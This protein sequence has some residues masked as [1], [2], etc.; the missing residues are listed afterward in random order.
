MF[1]DPY[2]FELWTSQAKSFKIASYGIL[3]GVAL[4]IYQN[5]D[6][7]DK[8]GNLAEK[9]LVE[10]ISVKNIELGIGTDLTSIGD[11]V[12]KLY[13]T[14]S[15]YYA[16]S[17]PEANDRTMGIVWYN[18]DDDNQYLGFSDGV[19]DLSYDEEVYIAEAA[20][21]NKIAS[22]LGSSEYS[23]D[24]DSLL[25]AANLG[26]ATPLAQEIEKLV[27][28]TLWTEIQ[29]L[30]KKI[31]GKGDEL[32]GYLETAVTNLESCIS[33]IEKDYEQVLIYWKK[34]SE[35]SDPGIVTLSGKTWTN[36]KT[37]YDELK[38]NIEN[39]LTGLDKSYSDVID[40]YTN[41][42]N[43]VF[44]Q[45]EAKYNTLPI[46][47]YDV[48]NSYQSKTNFKTYQRKDFSAYANKYCIYWFRADEA[49]T[50]S[51]CGEGWSRIRVDPSSEDPQLF[52]KGEAVDGWYRN[53]ARTDVMPTFSMRHDRPQ[54]KLK[55]ILFYNHEKFESN[56][57]VF[58]NSEEIPDF[59]TLDKTDTGVISHGENSR[60]QYFVYNIAGALNDY[61]DRTRDRQLI[62]HYDGLLAKD[63]ALDY[64][65]IYWYIPNKD[66]ASMLLVS[67]KNELTKVNSDIAGYDAYYKKLGAGDEN[68]DTTRSFWYKIK[69]TYN[70]GFSFNTIICKMYLQGSEIPVIVE[71]RFSFGTQ[72]TSGTKYT[73]TVNPQLGYYPAT[74][75][76]KLTLDVK[77]YDSNF[78]EVAIPYPD[79]MEIKPLY[80]GNSNSINFIQDDNTIVAGEGTYGLFDVS[81]HLLNGEKQ[82]TGA[83]RVSIP[84]TIGGYYLSGPTAI[85][86]NSLGTLDRTSVYDTSYKL[87]KLDTNEEV[88]EVQWS[89]SYYDNERNDITNSN[90]I[91]AGYL[92][93]LSADNRLVPAELYLD[94][95]TCYAVVNAK[96]SAGELYWAQPIII[97]QNQYASTTLNGWNGEFK[98][99]ENKGTILGT[100]F[101]AGRKTANN[102]FEGVVM[103]DVK[104]GDSANSELG[105]YGYH[106]GAQSF[107]FKTDGTGFIG[108]SGRGRILFDGQNSTIQSAGYE[109][110]KNGM[111]I[112]LDNGTLNMQS[113]ELGQIYFSVDADAK[114]PNPVFKIIGPAPDKRP[115]LFMN[116]GKY[117]LQSLD[118]ADGSKGMK[119]DL[120][121][122]KILANNFTLIGGKNLVIKSNPAESSSDYYFRFGNDET[123]GLMSMDG[124]GNLSIA[125]NSFKLVGKGSGINL[126]KQT[127]PSYVK[128]KESK[129]K[130]WSDLSAWSPHMGEGCLSGYE[131]TDEPDKPWCLQVSNGGYISQKI[132]KLPAGDY[133]LSGWVY[134]NTSDTIPDVSSNLKSKGDIYDASDKPEANKWCYFKKTYTLATSGDVTIYFGY[135]EGSVQSSRNFWLWHCKFEQGTQATEWTDSV[136][137]SFTDYDQNL[138]FNQLTNNGDSQ[139]IYLQD[140]ELYVSASVI[141]TGILRDAKENT[142]WDLGNGTLTSKVFSLTAG[143]SPN[144]I[145]IN[146]Q[147]STYPLQIG[148]N[149]KVKWDG[150]LEATNATIGGSITANAINAKGLVANANGTTISSGATIAGWIIDNNSIRTGDLGKPGSMWLCR[151]GTTTKASFNKNEPVKAGWCI[152]IGENFGVDNEGK[153]FATSAVLSGTIYADE[154]TIGPLS[155]NK[156]RLSFGGESSTTPIE[157]TEQVQSDLSANSDA[158]EGKQEFTFTIPIT[159]AHTTN[160][161]TENISLISYESGWK[162]NKWVDETSFANAAWKLDFQ[163]DTDG[164]ITSIKLKSK[165]KFTSVGDSFYPKISVGVVATVEVSYSVNITENSIQVQKID[166]PIIMGIEAKITRLQDKVNALEKKVYQK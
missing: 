127:C 166:S 15:S 3:S 129:E 124:K 108:K 54:E 23:Q 99:D 93:K 98:L 90:K 73:L 162:D 60:N 114:Q 34:K 1:G 83:V 52:A 61:A 159:L 77:V 12:L 64:A 135:Y 40:T 156:D 141:A 51:I 31:P 126:L 74:N 131:N 87:Y 70:S 115:L 104:D 59:S 82:V 84:W 85:V 71:E 20:E 13:T 102:T 151:S 101:A 116:D 44:I 48:I 150:T 112:D 105:L 16:Y 165:F 7:I 147:A 123:P 62:C 45:I 155:I 33:N 125:V 111:L 46:D 79:T 10:N 17:T 27:S 81:T 157:W 119:I 89:I 134:C 72:S 139:G 113:D 80:Y 158:L 146:S 35:Q 88:T 18:K 149:F 26:I 58:T 143:T 107:G 47:D 128:S 163:K 55:V 154:G 144:Q 106:Q 11:D 122:G 39:S 148:S 67:D 160:V 65:Q 22:L 63:E 5:N 142:V 24:K 152:G 100:M 53:V 96:S 28:Q 42:I 97:M 110:D 137:T 86:Y 109:I 56:E 2:A 130:V 118:Y 8:Q 91:E 121:E 120:A 76:N 117:Y 136:E 37:I 41:R 50:D 19:Y 69:D 36:I 92:P 14:D 153:L 94:G 32:K 38:G 66:R 49:A 133:T 140:G 43:K 25:L 95:L 29:A 161:T 164:Y 57:L 145:V 78:D 138:I 103:G 9:A 68:N 30:S 6:F 75:A 132:S 4:S 21:D